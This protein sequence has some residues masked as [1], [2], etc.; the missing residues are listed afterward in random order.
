MVNRLT[1]QLQRNKYLIQSKNCFRSSM[2]WHTTN[3]CRIFLFPSKTIFNENTPWLHLYCPNIYKLACLH[4]YTISMRCNAIKKNST[5]GLKGVL[6]LEGLFLKSFI[7]II[8]FLVYNR[9]WSNTLA[10]SIER[11]A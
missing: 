8:Y 5:A 3:H 2:T 10:K 1:A 6:C 11:T 7:F 4:K 9:I